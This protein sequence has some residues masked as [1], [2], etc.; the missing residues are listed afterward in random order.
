MDK[1]IPCAVRVGMIRIEVVC[2]TR[3]GD[4][5]AV[6]RHEPVIPRLGILVCLLS[7]AVLAHPVCG[8]S[9]GFRR[10]D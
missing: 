10:N 9:Q 3:V 8:L 4:V 2:E 7:Q 1:Y 5:T 6:G